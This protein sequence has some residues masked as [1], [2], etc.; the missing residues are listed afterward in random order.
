MSGL[1]YKRHYIFIDPNDI[2]CNI[3]NHPI[4]QSIKSIHKNYYINNEKV[5]YWSYVMIRELLKKYDMELHD[6][7]L[8]IN[9]NYPALLADIGRQVILYYYGGV[10][11]DL[12]CMSNINLINYLNEKNVKIIAETNPIDESRVRNMNIIAL[13][14]KHHFINDTLQKIKAALKEAKEKRYKG[15]DEVWNIGSKIYLEVFK[16]YECDGEVIKD[17]LVLKRLIYYDPNI[18]NKNIKKWQNTD[19]YLIKEVV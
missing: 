15:G 11:H 8:E 5:I 18:Y 10:Y 9:T 12:K 6:L 1:I 3:N 7:F 19:E 16:D 4:L 17:K 13:S 2:N 14:I